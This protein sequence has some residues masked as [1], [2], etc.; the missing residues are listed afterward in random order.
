MSA[1]NPTVNVAPAAPAPT[2]ISST[3]L[4]A[5]KGTLKN[6]TQAVTQLQQFCTQ[7]E[8]QVEQLNRKRKA[9]NPD[10]LEPPTT[11]PRRTL[12]TNTRGLI[13]ADDGKCLFILFPLNCHFALLKVLK[14][15]VNFVY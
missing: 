8:Q 14:S 5:L 7:A 11:V 15:L 4:L 3:R 12:S 9:G 2:A 1:W 10:P 13:T 6:M